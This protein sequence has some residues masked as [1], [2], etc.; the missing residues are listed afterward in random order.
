MSKNIVNINQDFANKLKRCLD[1]RWRFIYDYYILG[2]SL[3][4]ICKS[5]VMRCDDVTKNKIVYNALLYINNSTNENYIQDNYKE[6]NKLIIGEHIINGKRETISFGELCVN[7][8]K[9]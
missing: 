9:I 6:L 3:L 5:M 8:N 1:E 4:I 7:C 2:A